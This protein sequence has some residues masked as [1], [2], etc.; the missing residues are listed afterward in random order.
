MA[1]QNQKS[2]V[3]LKES[4]MTASFHRRILPIII[5][6][7]SIFGLQIG[8]SDPA[9]PEQELIQAVRNSQQEKVLALLEQGTNAN[10]SDG[11]Y[12]TVLIIASEKGDIEIVKI[13]IQK[14]ANV[15]AQSDSHAT[16]LALAAQSGHLEVVQLLLKSGAQIHWP[17]AYDPLIFA[18]WNGHIE[19]VKILLEAGADPNFKDGSGK[20]SLMHAAEHRHP[21]IVRL[22]IEHKAKVN[23][24]DAEQITP[25]MYAVLGQDSESAE[26]LI[27]SGADPN[28][29]TNAGETALIFS[30]RD[31]H[32]AIVQILVR[33]GADIF[34]KD[35]QGLDAVNWAQRELHHDIV[36]ELVKSP[37]AIENLIQDLTPSYPNHPSSIDILA[38]MKEKRAVEPLLQILKTERDPQTQWHILA[39]LEKIG[40][41]K[42]IP[43]FIQI[44]DQRDRRLYEK[45]LQALV[46]LKALSAIPALRHLLW[47]PKKAEKAYEAL[48]AL[49]DDSYLKSVKKWITLFTVMIPLTLFLVLAFMFFISVKN[50]TMGLVRISIG[51]ADAFLAFKVGIIASLIGRISSLGDPPLAGLIFIYGGYCSLFCFLG[52][53]LRIK[54]TNTFL[55][56]LIMACLPLLLAPAFISICSLIFENIPTGPLAVL[57]FSIDELKQSQPQVFIRTLIP[58]ITIGVV[59]FVNSI[60]IRLIMKPI[61]KKGGESC[62]DHFSLW[63]F[64]GTLIILYAGL[65]LPIPLTQ[66]VMSTGT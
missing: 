18:S 44:L 64:W 59:C 33:S 61:L 28:A 16:A 45:A 3:L 2:P 41:E 57:K 1:G 62:L 46:G 12:G 49:G 17:D 7:F 42:A 36:S 53:F 54:G 47:N 60:S 66:W 23:I 4:K 56:A 24:K 40:D 25:L 20:T 31:G 26:A 39:A 32:Q 19:I 14:G 30:A 27:Q 21:D 29:Q 48:Q 22:L 65:F 10:T 13:L 55:N 38:S 50:K 11:P 35:K 15:N 58:F 6:L 5:L 34:L 9:N 63:G 8:H 52:T 37:K 43:A 51:L